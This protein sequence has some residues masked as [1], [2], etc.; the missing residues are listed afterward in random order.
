VSTTLARNG[1]KGKHD[2]AC[3]EAKKQTEKLVRKTDVCGGG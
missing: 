1:E 3:D 2:E